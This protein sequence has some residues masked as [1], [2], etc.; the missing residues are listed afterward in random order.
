MRDYISFFSWSLNIY[1]YFSLKKYKTF[2]SPKRETKKQEINFRR[3][4]SSFRCRENDPKNVLNV[5]WSLYTFSAV[6]FGYFGIFRIFRFFSGVRFT[7]YES[8]QFS[9]PDRNASLCP[10]LFWIYEYTYILYS[11]SKTNRLLLF[12]V[13]FFSFCCCRCLNCLFI[14]YKLFKYR[15]KLFF[16]SFHQQICLWAK[17]VFCC[18]IRWLLWLCSWSWFHWSQ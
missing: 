13:F 3:R 4:Y 12:S 2:K 7:W 18:S 10:P 11:N 17:N 1:T 16:V 5:V 15:Y 8:N 9:T 14:F 6:D